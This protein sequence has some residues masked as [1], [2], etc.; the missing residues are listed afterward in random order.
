M[1]AWEYSWVEEDGRLPA[2]LWLYGEVIRVVLGRWVL[3][4]GFQ[5]IEV[6]TVQVGNLSGRGLGKVWGSKRG[7]I[8]SQEV[9]VALFGAAGPFSV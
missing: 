3:E 4:G 9:A 5:V 1:G 8:G 2:L 6:A 7:A